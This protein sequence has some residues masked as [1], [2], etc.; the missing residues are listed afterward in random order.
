MNKIAIL[1][2]GGYFLK[3]LPA[4]CPDVDPRDES[5]VVKELGNLVVSHLRRHNKVVGNKHP[6]SNL[7]RV[8]YYDA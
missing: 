8:F 5:A 1:I 2:D 7:Y 6:R 3:R 4:V